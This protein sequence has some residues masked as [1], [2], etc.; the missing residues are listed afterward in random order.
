MTHDG[1]RM[2]LEAAYGYEIVENEFCVP[3]WIYVSQK[4]IEANKDDADIKKNFYKDDGSLDMP[5]VL[6]SDVSI[7]FLRTI[8]ID[9]IAGSGKSKGVLKQIIGI[10][11]QDK[12][13]AN[14]LFSNL[15]I[16]HTTK[17]KAYELA[18]D[19]FGEERAKAM[20][21]TNCFSHAGLMQMISGTKAEGKTW[22]ETTDDQGN[23]V[24]DTS[25]MARDENGV[26][27]YNFGINKTVTKHS[28]II[29]DEVSHISLPSLKLID[30]FAEY[31][32]I[33]H[34]TFGDFDQ[35]GI[36]LEFNS[37]GETLKPWDPVA[38]GTHY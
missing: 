7:D 15:W 21:D 31:A 2:D 18:V 5:R 9:G 25:T 23:V 3:F 13:L 38:G 16:T 24:I 4:Y 36:S 8:L 34:L 32:G 28:L 11:D 33:H 29:N 6:D 22:N 12:D 20:K 35:T 1:Q 27:G 37:D 26:W 10:I 19:T 17:E 30:K 14:S